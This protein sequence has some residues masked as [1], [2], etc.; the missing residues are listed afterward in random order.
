MR[1]AVRS[2]ALCALLAQ[3]SPAATLDA[4]EADGWYTW[5]VEAV[6][7]GP[8]W[9]C[10]SWN[11][12]QAAPCACNLDSRHD[13]YGS[14]DGHEPASGEVRL[15]ARIE[16]GEV[17][18][19]RT[20]SPRCA[21]ESRDRITDLGLIDAGQSFDWLRRRVAEDPAVAE[22]AL[23]AIAM[24]RGDAPLAFLVDAANGSAEGDLRESA[25]FWLGQVRIAEAA[26]VIERLMFADE[27]ATI[28]RHAAFALAQAK[29]AGRAKAL[30]RQGRED[31]DPD[32]RS[33]AWF[34]LAQT[35]ASESESAIMRA[36]VDDP[37]HEVR[38]E[39]VFALSQL[40]G[41]RA[42]DALLSV[43]ENR[44][45]DRELRKSALFWLVQSDSDRAFSSVERLL[46]E[47]PVR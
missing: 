35:G 42:V 20:L 43:L 37:G 47:N 39:A 5:R 18:K 1:R 22:D 23:A 8:E 10:V 2:L 33:N 19:L 17:A 30:I 9:C 16:S 4:L 45:L 46:V 36:M 41:D 7:G 29:F 13:G 12:G 32:V 31:K 38:E 26:P 21:V 3:P 27:S 40:P 44:G 25:I 14:R 24:H 11:R 34:W 6:E 15:Y 28:R